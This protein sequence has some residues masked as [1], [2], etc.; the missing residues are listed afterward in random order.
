MLSRRRTL[1]LAAA[2][3]PTALILGRHAF[4]SAEESDLLQLVKAGKLGQAR[5]LAARWSAASPD[6]G[7]ARLLAGV[8]SFATGAYSE[9][10]TWLDPDYTADNYIFGSLTAADAGILRTKLGRSEWLYL[11]SQRAHVPIANVLAP[12]LLFVAT[13][14]QTVD[15]YAAQQAI[16][17]RALYDSTIL[18][19]TDSPGRQSLLDSLARKSEHEHRCTGNLLLA[20]MA[21]ARDDIATARTLLSS[22][23]RSVLPELLEYHIANAELA[24]LG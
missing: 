10:R 18:S 8:L 7:K 17:E 3:I 24:R 11:A 15:E 14:H 5:D 9:A 23:T 4:A 20:E 16:A 13:G 6:D 1:G 22:A 2:L 19:V 12:P 21:L